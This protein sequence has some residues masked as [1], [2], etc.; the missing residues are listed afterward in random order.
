ML[1][2]GVG[3]PTEM[4]SPGE[5]HRATFDRSLLGLE[6]MSS[7]GS[8]GGGGNDEQMEAMEEQREIQD[9]VNER[10]WEYEWEQAQTRYN[11]SL[12]RNALVR[13]QNEEQAL[14]QEA[15]KKQAW[16]YQMDIRR[17]KYE[18]QVAQYNKAERM[19]ETQINYNQVASQLATEAA[20][21]VRD[22]RFDSVMYQGLEQAQ[23]LASTRA[24]ID[25]ARGKLD[26]QML[27]KATEAAQQK[28]ALTLDRQSKRA[29]AA[30][31]SQ[32][33]LIKSIQQTGQA[34]SKGQ[35]GRSAAKT[36][37]SMVADYGRVSAQ[38]ADQVNRADSAYNLSMVGI[39]KGLDLARTDY[40][41]TRGDLSTKEKFAQL[42][43]DLGEDQRQATKLSIGKS[44][45]REIDKIKHDQYGANLRAD[46]QRMAKPGMPPEPPKP[47][48]LPRTQILDP[49][50]PVAPPRPI[51]GQGSPTPFS[52]NAGQ[53]S[54]STA[55]MIGGGL[56][57]AGSLVGM[58]NPWVGGAMMLGGSILSMF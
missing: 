48:E 1:N 28:Q 57:S 52:S 16:Q 40:H 55:G 2:M 25:T 3:V 21:A 19:Y 43:Y 34:K 46:G 17:H 27:S 11:D 9:E 36:Y 5:R 20:A 22:E 7:G 58:F 42:G 39:D 37:Q 38:L 6:M 18:G 53:A 10:Q 50:A 29:D 4:L 12:I 26:V 31:S 32:S 30:F 15:T 24:G 13:K 49:P 14:Y 35:A 33:N 23:K 44:Y 47:L 41:M 54:M 51:E 45:G 56:A 8:S